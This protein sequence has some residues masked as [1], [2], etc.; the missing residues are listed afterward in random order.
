MRQHDTWIS[1]QL[2]ALRCRM[3]SAKVSEE[4]KLTLKWYEEL[5]DALVKRLPQPQSPSAQV[6]R[7][8]REELARVRIRVQR[9][10]ERSAGGLRS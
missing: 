5:E 4:N 7:S 2:T 8:P 10:I 9:G 1:A 6:G 3:D